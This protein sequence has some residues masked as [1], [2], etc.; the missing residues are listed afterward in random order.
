MPQSELPTVVSQ[1][2]YDLLNTNTNKAALGLEG[3]FDGDQSL[4]PSTP[5]V[6]VLMGNYSRELTGAPFRTDNV[7]TIYLMVYHAKV[8]DTQLTQRE[9][10]A[11]AE[12]IMKFL[13]TDKTMGGNVIHGFVTGMEPGQA[14][15]GKTMAHVTRITWS[16]LTKTLT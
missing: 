11:F 15:M 12:S 16:G 2:I 7:F 10:M 5:A 9:C 6:C 13:H 3:V 14:P 1:Y 4:I 8:Q